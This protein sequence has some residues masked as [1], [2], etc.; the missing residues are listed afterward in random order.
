MQISKALEKSGGPI[1][2][3]SCG[4]KRTLLGKKRMKKSGDAEKGTLRKMA[5]G[6]G[7]SYRTEEDYS[8]KI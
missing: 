3:G 1:S 2:K 8:V 7:S 4:R 6:V 5:F